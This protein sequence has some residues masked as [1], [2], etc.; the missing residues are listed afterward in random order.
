LS[1]WTLL[2]WNPP[3]GAAEMDILTSAFVLSKKGAYSFFTVYAF[4]FA[5]SEKYFFT[6]FTCLFL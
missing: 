6:F 5:F 2:Q 3:Y 1:A 4:M